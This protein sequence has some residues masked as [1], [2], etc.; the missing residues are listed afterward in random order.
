MTSN[1]S[2]TKMHDGKYLIVYKAV[3]K[4]GELPFGGPVTHQTAIAETPMGPIKKHSK[5]IFYKEG[6]HFPAEDP[7]VW[8]HPGSKRY[9]GIVK[10]MNG[11]FTGQGVSLAFFTSRDGLNWEPSKNPLAFTLEIR[12]ADG[13]VDKV[14]RLERA[15]VL[16]EIGEPVMLYCACAIGDPF[17]TETFNVHIPLKNSSGRDNK[18]GI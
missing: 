11:T 9:Y 14:D 15:Q 13:T 8:Y 3:A 18:S 4:H 7:F 5:R 12:W 6:E 2:V 10:D 17:S 16:L 1:P